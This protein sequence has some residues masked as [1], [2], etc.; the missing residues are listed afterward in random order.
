MAGKINLIVSL[1]KNPL[2]FSP[3]DIFKENDNP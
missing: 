1:M 2:G 3:L